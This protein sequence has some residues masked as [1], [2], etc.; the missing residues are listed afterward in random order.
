M[1]ATK[2]D[3]VWV[4]KTLAFYSLCRP[5][6]AL[7][8]SQLMSAASISRPLRRSRLPI[9]ASRW[10]DA[11]GKNGRFLPC[12][13]VGSRR[14]LLAAYHRGRVWRGRAQRAGW[15]WAW[16]A[17]GRSEPFQGSHV[18]VHSTRMGAS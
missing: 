5:G 6:L 16:G 10:R 11:Q 15:V 2:A 3:R 1:A 13:R 4:F 17:E 7:L 18:E 8:A 12:S 14:A 9:D